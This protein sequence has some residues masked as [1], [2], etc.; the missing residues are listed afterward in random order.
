MLYIVEF[1]RNTKNCIHF[2]CVE[3]VAAQSKFHIDLSRYIKS[4]TYDFYLFWHLITC[5][6]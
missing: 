2:T 4:E 5:H 1:C 6:K 3:W